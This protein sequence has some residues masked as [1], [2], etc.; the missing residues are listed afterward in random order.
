MTKIH[1]LRL[2]QKLHSE[3]SDLRQII[4]MNNCFAEKN[5]EHYLDGVGL[6]IWEYR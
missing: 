5:A 4:F 6:K 2:K 1:E 3:D